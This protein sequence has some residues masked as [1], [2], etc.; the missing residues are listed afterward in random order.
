MTKEQLIEKLSELI[1]DAQ[2]DFDQT[3]FK[4]ENLL[5]EYIADEEVSFAY[6]EIGQYYK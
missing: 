5:L 1:T 6:R 4:A 2:N 3:H